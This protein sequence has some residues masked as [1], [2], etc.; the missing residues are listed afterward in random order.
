MVDT[1]VLKTPALWAYGFESRPEYFCAD[2][3]IYL[4]TLWVGG[5]R[6]GF[7]QGTAFVEA[8]PR[9]LRQDLAKVPTPQGV[10]EFESHRLRFEVPPLGAF[11]GPSLE[12]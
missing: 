10:R 11:P 1:G 7:F 6:S 4:T 5:F 12:G 3:P 8:W 2:L 9:G